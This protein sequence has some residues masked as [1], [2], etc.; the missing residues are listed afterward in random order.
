M[1][2]LKITVGGD[3]ID[4]ARRHFVDAWHRA[5][6]GEDFFERHLAFENR[7]ALTRV[8]TTARAE[9][10]GFVRRHDATSVRKFTAAPRRSD[11][12]I[13]ADFDALANRALPDTSEEPIDAA[14]MTI[15]STITF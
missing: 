14:H 2:D 6:R 7:N 4:E 8:L 12:D 1:G 10:I 9:L 13:L 5:E 15:E 11:H 3:V